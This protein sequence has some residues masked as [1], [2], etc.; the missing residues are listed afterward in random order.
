[1]SMFTRGAAL[2][3]FRKPVILKVE[4]EPPT[5]ELGVIEN[6]VAL[7]FAPGVNPE[8]FDVP[9]PPEQFHAPLTLCANA[10]V[11]PPVQGLVA[12]A[13]DTNTCVPLVCGGV[14]VRAAK[15]IGPRVAPCEN[16]FVPVN[17]LLVSRFGTV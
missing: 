4:V 6:G 2:V 16:W 11:P 5:F 7:V 9:P 17:T 12:D 13:S 10:P 1:M 15:R 14:V 3:S 8:K